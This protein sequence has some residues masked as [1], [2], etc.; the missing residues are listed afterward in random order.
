MNNH[1]GQLIKDY[2]YVLKILSNLNEYILVTKGVRPH[3]FL[4]N[5]PMR[6]AL[7]PALST[8]QPDGCLKPLYLPR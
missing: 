8:K 6:Q 3:C 2:V 1:Q 4:S 7:R 5:S